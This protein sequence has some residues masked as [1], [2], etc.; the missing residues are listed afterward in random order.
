[1]KNNVLRQKN[2]I[3]LPCEIHLDLHGMKSTVWPVGRYKLTKTRMRTTN[4]AS[5]HYIN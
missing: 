1:M 2:I 3:A 5:A 4:L